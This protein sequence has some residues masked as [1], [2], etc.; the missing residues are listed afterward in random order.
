[1]MN[2]TENRNRKRRLQHVLAFALAFFVAATLALPLDTETASAA[3]PAFSGRPNVNAKLKVIKRN[4]KDVN[5]RLEA[6]QTVGGYDTLQGMC[7]GGGYIYYLLWHQT[8]DMCKVVRLNR[9]D[10]TTAKVSKSLRL[11]HGNDMTYNSKTNRLVVSNARPARKRLTVINP[12]SLT[13]EKVKDI[14]L[15]KDLPGIDWDRINSKGGY[16]GFNNIAYNAKY[17]Q[18]VIQLYETRDFVFLD[19]NFN[20]VRYVKPRRWDR[21]VYQGMDSFDNYIVV[22]NSIGRGGPENVLSVYDWNGNYVSRVVLNRAK[23]LECVFHQ[24]N[25]LY[26]GFYYAH[27]EKYRWAVKTKKVRKT[28]KVKVK[29]KIKKGKNKGKYKT[30]T[31]KKKKMVT[32]KTYVKANKGRRWLNRDCYVYQVTNL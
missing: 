9:S 14:T 12:N 1:M 7:Y 18:Y 5:L 32:V 21:Q 3:G 15:P 4:F 19:A 17:N 29:K 13:I 30:V 11:N 22:C 27:T 20:P 25:Q 8:K 16:N 23:E 10:M 6:Q 28:V 24:G 31:K 26:A 2:R